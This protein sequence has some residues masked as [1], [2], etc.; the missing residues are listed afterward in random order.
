MVRGKQLGLYKRGRKSE[1][2]RGEPRQSKK[3]R[4]KQSINRK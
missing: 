2:K 1:E 4:E 3:T